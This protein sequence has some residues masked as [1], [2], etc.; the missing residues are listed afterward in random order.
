[1]G[2]TECCSH[3]SQPSVRALPTTAPGAGWWV[4]KQRAG[5]LQNQGCVLMAS[6]K[7]KSYLE[8]L[9]LFLRSYSNHGYPLWRKSACFLKP[10][11]GLW[12]NTAMEKRSWQTDEKDFRLCCTVII[13]LELGIHIIL[14][15]QCARIF[16][17]PYDFDGILT[18]KKKKK[19]LGIFIP[20]PRPVIF[21]HWWNES[22]MH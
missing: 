7:D 2:E 15:W 16:F 22:L 6:D 13:L 1:M 5:R 20:C 11:A 9:Q 8:L 3:K 17:F 19:S 4:C 12:Q 14:V 21:N 18:G 10:C